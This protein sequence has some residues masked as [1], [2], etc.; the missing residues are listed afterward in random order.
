MNPKSKQ[1]ILIIT[2]KKLG[3]GHYS[4]AKA[5]EA[6]LK[7]RNEAKVV[8]YD[9][10]FPA[11][12]I[13]EF[14]LKKMP[15]VWKT[16]IKVFNSD[17]YINFAKGYEKNLFQGLIGRVYK[18][19]DKI[20]FTVISGHYIGYN[21]KI[22]RKSYVLITDYLKIDKQWTL[23]SP[24][25]F[26]VSDDL[27]AKE[28]HNSDA[29]NSSTDI[30]VTGIPVSPLCK[31]I[32]TKSKEELRK[33]LKIYDSNLYTI[34]GGGAGD[35]SLKKVFKALSKY[36]LA[37]KKFIIICGRN[38]RYFEFF[39]AKVKELNLEK[40]I[41]IRGFAESDQIL[42][43]F[44][45]SDIVI[46]KPGGITLTELINLHT[47]IAIPFAHPQEYGNRDIVI[48]NGMGVT[49]FRPE[50]IWEKVFMLSKN[51][52]QIFSKNMKK[53]SRYDSAKR[54]VDVVLQ[55]DVKDVNHSR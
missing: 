24:H 3:A 12:T 18:D 23:Y 7:K 41:E 13:Y 17:T 38:K 10:K 55:T 16:G 50:E 54:I 32:A 39:N 45:A 44:R 5:I 28:L 47:P 42:K 48:S 52:L 53:F 33:N 43:L 21:K 35:K 29:Y 51:E 49:S 9:W 34:V 15:K 20:I 4:A 27:T 46:T 37:D 8:F 36:N 25:T 30:V 1:K 31:E 2:C 40:N 11:G 6:E 22:S 19:F 26:F 14:L